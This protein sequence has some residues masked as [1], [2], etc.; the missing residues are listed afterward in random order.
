MCVVGVMKFGNAVPRGGLEHTYLAFKTI[1][2]PVH[3][4]GFLMLPLYPP[5]PVC[6]AACLRG[7]CRLLF[8][9]ICEEL[10]FKTL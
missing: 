9:Y 5:P 6:A 10:F 1:V 3:H 7:H 2:L 8:I 4:I